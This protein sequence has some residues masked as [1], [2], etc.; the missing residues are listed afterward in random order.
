VVIGELNQWLAQ[1]P[2]RP[3][4]AGSPISIL[5]HSESGI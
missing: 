1:I 5:Q 3:T 4:K 2:G